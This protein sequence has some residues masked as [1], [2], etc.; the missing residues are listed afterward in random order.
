[1]PTVTRDHSAIHYTVTGDGDGLP[2]ICLHGGACRG[3]DFDA[4]AD[5]LRSQRQVVSVDLR[6]HGRS[7]ASQ[8]PYDPVTLAGDAL[9]IVDELGLGPVVV[10]GHS[11]GGAIALAM[12]QRGGDVAAI[13]SIDAPLVLSEGMGDGMRQLVGAYEAGH[14][15]P[16]FRQF[17]QSVVGFGGDERA[18]H[19]ML[20]G[21]CESRDEVVHPLVEAVVLFDGTEALE[22]SDFPILQIDAGFGVCDLERLLALRPNAWT[23]KTAGTGHYP[24]VE[25]PAQ[26]VAMMRHFFDHHDL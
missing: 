2:L 21:L 14:G 26:I 1:M 6:G 25:S 20:E 9:A 18:R 11:L 23:A 3:S 24:H 17:M 15:A 5:A 4:I 10:V 12:V 13:V 22:R 8:G 16:A 19:Q 7:V